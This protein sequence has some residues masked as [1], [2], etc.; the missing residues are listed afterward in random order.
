MGKW[1]WS[2]SAP[3]RSRVASGTTA[4]V[5]RLE[6]SVS[7]KVRNLV[8]TRRMVVAGAVGCSHDRGFVCVSIY[9]QGKDAPT[10]A[11]APAS[12]TATAA[13]AA[14]ANGGAVSDVQGVIHELTV[15]YNSDAARYEGLPPGW[16]V[17]TVGTVVVHVMQPG[18]WWHE[19]N[20][21][22]AHWTGLQ[23]SVRSAVGAVS[24]EQFRGL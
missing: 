2:N 22:G 10:A 13:S 7:K 20:M 23:L 8:N 12:G 1:L 17:R 24:E 3:I 16:E 19:C 14:L 11:S 9:L 21:H 4:I 15:T 18:V 6:A 5:H